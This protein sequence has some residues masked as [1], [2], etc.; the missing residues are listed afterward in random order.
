MKHI[1]AFDDFVLNRTDNT[2]RVFKQPD[3]RFDCAYQD[4]DNPRGIWPTQVVPGLDGGFRLMYTGVPGKDEAIDDEHMRLFMAEST[5]GL[6]FTPCRL[7]G[8]GRPYPHMAGP[9]HEPNGAFA[10]LDEAETDPAQRY[11]AVCA[12]YGYDASGRL[13]EESARMYASADLLHWQAVNDAAVT[14]SYVDCYLSLLRN[15]VTGRFQMTTRRRWGE[16]RICLVESGDLS[17]WTAPRAIV[18]PLPDDE[19]LTHLYSMPHAYYRA[20]DVFIGMLWKHVMPFDRVMEGPV[21]SEYA[22]SYDGLMW[23][24]TRAPMFTPTQ[25]GQYGAGSA[26]VVS[27]VERADDVVF[28]MSARR[29]EHG[30]LPGGWQDGMPS[31]S[32]LVPGVLPR[33]RFVCIDSGKGRAQL[34]TQWLRLKQPALTLNTVAPFG[35]LRAQLETDGPLEGFAFEDCEPISGDHLDAPLRWRG[36]D[37]S[38]LQAQG[39]W[40]RLRIAFEQAEVYAISGDFDFTINTRA[41]AYE[42]L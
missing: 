10:Y 42:R 28:Y 33:N 3:W 22:Y 34:L 18:H 21:M 2:R 36:G 24:R 25:R 9:L 20:G 6:H 19:P 26:Y 27:M 40:F 37:L 8:E 13:V 5:D 38:A 41:P 14:P 31:E 12:R 4:A 39:R 29:A 15:P 1:L 32:V 7:P 11:K 16:R 30:G 17:R 23:N 35:A